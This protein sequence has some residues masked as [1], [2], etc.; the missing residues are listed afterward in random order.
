MDDDPSGWPIGWTACAGI[1]MVMGGVWWIISSIVAIANDTFFVVGEEYIFQFDVTTWGWIHLLL[2]IVILLAG[3]YLFTG[4]VWARTVGA[5]V[6]VLW[7]MV[8]FAWQPRYP[9]WALTVHG[10]DIA[11]PY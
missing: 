5:I 9:V 1:M 6:A 7:A 8:A 11:D 4:A 3:F 10:R 2:G